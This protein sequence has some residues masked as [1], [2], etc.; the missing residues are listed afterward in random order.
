MYP[1][2]NKDAPVAVW[3]NGGPGASSTFANFLF[4]G[5][6]RIRQ[7][8]DDPS[9]GKGAFEAYTVQENWLDQA[10]M[11]YIDQPVGTGFSYTKSEKQEEDYLTDMESAAAEFV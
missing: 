9:S 11:I 2:T 6:M 8:T 3:L 4:N 10:T 5:P 1:A 7:M